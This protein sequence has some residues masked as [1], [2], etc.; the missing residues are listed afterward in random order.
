MNRE[1]SQR[2]LRNDSGA[3]LRAVESG[4]SF[5]VT[6][7]GVPVAELAPLRRRRFVGA[8]RIVEAFRGS[9]HLDLQALRDDLDRVADPDPTPRG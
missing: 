4:E 9:P 7:N 3:I 2:E 5:T 1:I 8:Q 6:R